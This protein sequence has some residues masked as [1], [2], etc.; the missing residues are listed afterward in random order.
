MMENIKITLK[1]GSVKEAPKGSTVLEVAKLISMGLAK[2]ALGAT[3]NGEDVPVTV[4]EFN[5]LYKL[6]SIH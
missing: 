4:R 5:I 3:V 2:K 1:D 6:L